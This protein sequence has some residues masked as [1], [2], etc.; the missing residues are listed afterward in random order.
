[1]PTYEYSCRACGHK[2][3]EFQSILEEPLKRCPNCG[4]DNLDRSIG[5]GAGLIFKGTGFYLTD[6][7]KSHVS[8]DEGEKKKNKPESKE[9]KTEPGADTEKKA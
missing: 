8:R 6:Y 1:M 5:T 4:T 2:L 9:G 7:K 3:E